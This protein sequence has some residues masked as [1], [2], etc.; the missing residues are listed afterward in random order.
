MRAMGPTSNGLLTTSEPISNVSTSNAI[1]LQ[2]LR[3]VEQ[4]REATNQQTQSI[5]ELLRFLHEE[6]L[7]RQ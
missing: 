6:R 7:E 2:I 3:A 5:Q 4:Q 1:L